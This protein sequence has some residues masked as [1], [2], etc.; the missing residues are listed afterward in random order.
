MEDTEF[1]FANIPLSLLFHFNP[2]IFSSEVRKLREILQ[3]TKHTLYSIY[4]RK[5]EILLMV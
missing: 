1:Y 5:N 4:A 3:E 2:P